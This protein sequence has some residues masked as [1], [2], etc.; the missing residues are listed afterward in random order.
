MLSKF[1]RLRVSP[2]YLGT[3]GYQTKSKT[4]YGYNPGAWSANEDIGGQGNEA[5]DAR[6][7][8]Y[9]EAYRR[10][11]YKFANLNPVSLTEPVAAPELECARYGLTPSEAVMTPD[12]GEVTVSR[13]TMVLSDLYC[14]TMGLEVGH[15]ESEAEQRWLCD[16]QQE[17]KHQPL[18]ASV[19]RSLAL[20]MLKSQTF[21]NFLA[22]K[23]QSVKRY[24]GEGA[25]AMMGFFTQLFHQ[26]QADNIE[27]I[28]IA[29]AHRGRLNILTG[30]LGFP[31]VA[32]FR[33]MK[34]LPEFPPEQAGA[35]DVLSHLTASLDIGQCHVT[36]LPNPSHLEAVNPVAVGKTR[37]RHMSRAQGEYGASGDQRMGGAALCVQ[38]H[39]DAALA[40]QGINQETLQLANV[41][42]YSVG[43]SLHLVINNQV[44]FTTPGERGRSSRHCTDIAKQVSAPVLHVNGD[45]P[46]DV[47]R[48][49]R[50]ALE[51]RNTWRKDV[52]VN[53]ICFRRWGHNELDDPTFTN[54]SLYSVINKR[55]TVPDL[56]RDQ[57]VEQRV[58]SK[59][60]AGEAVT[61]HMA[62]LNE[63]LKSVD[64][65]KPV[66]SNL[67]GSWSS[68]SEPGSDI[69]TW[70]TGLGAEVLKWVGAQSVKVPESFNVHSHLKKHHIE[71][72]IKKLEAGSGLEWGTAEAL[73]IGSLLYQGNNVRISG[74]DVGRATFS[75]RHAMLVD[76]ASNEIHIPFNNME[77]GNEGR[78]EIANSILSEEAVLAFEYGMSVENPKNLI[79]WEAQFGDF[80]NGAQIILDT[81]V[82]S[83]E[84]KWGLQ[85][86]LV[87]LLPHGMDGAGP[88]HSSC[89]IERFLQMTDSAEAKADGDNI[90][91]EVVQPTT[92][93]QYFHLL[94]RQQIRNYRKP[95]VIVAP[96]T[97]L[98]LPAASSS[99][100]ELAPGTHF[101]QVLADTRAHNKAGVVRLIFV[102]G[103]HYYT[104]TKHIEEN[105]IQDSAVIR[106]ESLCPFPAGEIKEILESYSNVKTFVW[107]QEEQRNMGAWTFIAPRFQNVL[108]LSLK[109]VG[110][111]ELCQPAVG[112]G[113]VHQAENRS[114][115]EKTFA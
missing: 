39:G 94:R 25:E 11:G 55:G 87:M 86:G 105:N 33:K 35:G 90:N 102:S 47:V 45:H 19:K 106:L 6:V 4:V 5:E 70:D 50:I 1:K 73:A 30:L 26:A 65:Y 79:I 8:R 99:L 101:R 103:R 15:M 24:G 92:S 7:T 85:S 89:R 57:L 21:D 18:E 42:H 34:G 80:F 67:S 37:A 88:E 36:M 23:F 111:D 77:G 52:F 61:T 14:G 96:K 43:G 81:F 13:L 71:A 29:E 113:Q 93:A 60:E 40:G 104:L 64:T 46:E 9:I 78:L 72:R 115:L 98:R 41:P 91:W 51:Y 109:Y 31:P 95:L 48:A 84:S 59:D 56:Y 28:I 63:D 38:I 17:V 112:V 100:E 110:R 10:H 97:L 83:G 74:Q 27:D 20:E 2:S 3:R 58:L 75:H 82:G 49:T 32:M 16:K 22:T 107:S 53:L 12:Q 68:M 62:R 66:R 76:Q 69:S 114:I 44:G 108:G 54:P